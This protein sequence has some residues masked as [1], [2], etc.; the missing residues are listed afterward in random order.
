[1]VFRGIE[2]DSRKVDKDFLFIAVRGVKADGSAFIEE[3]L[4]RGAAAVVGES[5]PGVLKTRRIPFIPVS[6]S[7][8]AVARLAAAFPGAV[9]E[10]TSGLGAT[11]QVTLGR[12]APDVVEVPNRVG[13]S[14]LP[15]PSISSD[16]N[17]TQAIRTRKADTDI[18]S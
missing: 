1:M 11:V 12:G 6:E 7:R 3:A 9:V 13:S 16:P 15:S 14:P 8:I 10:K 18:C 5:L 2:C 4:S 17:P